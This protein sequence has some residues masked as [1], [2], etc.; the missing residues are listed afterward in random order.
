MREQYFDVAIINNGE[1]LMTVYYPLTKK[2]KRQL[3][4]LQ[5]KGLSKREMQIMAMVAKG[6]TN[7]EIGTK[8][9]ISK[10]TLKTHLNNIYKKLPKN[11]GIEFQQKRL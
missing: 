5:E 3:N 10:A 6:A 1:N 2:Y 8:L 11:S 4:Y 7:S 9:S